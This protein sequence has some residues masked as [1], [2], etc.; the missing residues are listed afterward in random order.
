MGSLIV[1]LWYNM[2]YKLIHSLTFKSSST[3][4]CK[5]IKVGRSYGTMEG[6][7]KSILS[8]WKVIKI[9]KIEK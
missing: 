1:S 7:E 5:D 4:G 6:A 9:L 2:D 3:L 8:E